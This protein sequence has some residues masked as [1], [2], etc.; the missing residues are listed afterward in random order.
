MT[1]QAVK[2]A[3]EPKHMAGYLRLLG[4]GLTVHPA[5]EPHDVL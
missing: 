1:A 3:F 4:G 5:P 2:K